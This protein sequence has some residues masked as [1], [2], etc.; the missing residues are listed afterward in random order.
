MKT[1]EQCTSGP[2]TLEP[3]ANR[4]EVLSSSKYGK[5]VQNGSQQCAGKPQESHERV[6]EIKFQ[7]PDDVLRECAEDFA[8]VDLSVFAKEAFVI[9]AYR[10]VI[11][12]E[13]LVGRA[14]GLDGSYDAGG[15]WLSNRNVPKN[16][17]LD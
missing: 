5:T 14:V 2:Q 11:F 17:P 15:E 10:R 1:V 6:M 16:G 9:E 3:T 8:G 13:R 7:I 4:K 12:G